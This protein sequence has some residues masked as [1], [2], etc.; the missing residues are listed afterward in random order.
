MSKKKRLKKINNMLLEMGAGKFFYRVERS[1]KDDNVEALISALNMMAEEIEE[2]LVHQGYANANETIKH[3]V[4]MSF[5]IDSKG[6]VEAVNQQACNILFYLC[7]DITGQPFESFLVEDSAQK[8]KENWKHLKQKNQSDSSIDLIF[9]TK[10]GLLV[11]SA[12]YINVIRGQD[13]INERILLTVVKHS[14]KQVELE[15]DLK[16]NTRIN[17]NF[18]EKLSPTSKPP[19]KDKVRLSQEDIRKIAEARDILIN[20]LDRE[21]PSIRDFALEIGTNS[22]K[23][24]YGFKELYGVSVFRFLRNERLRKAKMLVQYGD[25]PFKTIAQLCGF[26]SVPHFTRTFKKQFGYTPTELRNR[27]LSDDN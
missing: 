19:Q 16:Q 9:R 27:S 20:N 8:W 3:I 18:I 14:K 5:V 24:K 11:P 10:G 25:R 13:L 4:L 2:A 15:E 12:C 21:L 22:F 26:K 23:L 6:Y 7:D 1:L 17:S